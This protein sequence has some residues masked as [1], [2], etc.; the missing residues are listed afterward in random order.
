M[1]R[2]IP[3]ACE[4]AETSAMPMARSSDL[5]MSLMIMVYI[6][7]HNQVKVKQAVFG[8]QAVLGDTVLDHSSV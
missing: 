3:S 5:S 1:N 2:Q 6:A 4:A 7:Q 8:I